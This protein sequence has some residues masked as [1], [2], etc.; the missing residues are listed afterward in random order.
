MSPYPRALE[1]LSISP[2]VKA[3]F[4]LVSKSQGPGILGN[5]EATGWLLRNQDLGLQEGARHGPIRTNISVPCI[6]L[7]WGLDDF[8]SSGLGEGEG[9]PIGTQI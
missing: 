2:L 8:L 3:G 7:G 6:Q 1:P 9:R 4:L 5:P